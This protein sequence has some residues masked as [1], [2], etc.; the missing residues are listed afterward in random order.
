MRVLPIAACA[1]TSRQSTSTPAY[2]A[3]RAAIGIAGQEGAAQRLIVNVLTIVVAEEAA[4]DVGDLARFLRLGDDGDGIIGAVRGDHDA[5]VAR[6][7]RKGAQ[8]IKHL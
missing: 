5:R 4:G 2:A 3:R 1:A 8:M 6:M 7:E